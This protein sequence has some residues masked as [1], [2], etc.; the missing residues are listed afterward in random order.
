MLPTLADFFIAE[1]IADEQVVQIS[2]PSF[3]ANPQ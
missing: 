2:N 1:Y 3:N